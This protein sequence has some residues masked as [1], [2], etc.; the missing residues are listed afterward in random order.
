METIAKIKLFSS[1]KTGLIN[2]SEQLKTALNTQFEIARNVNNEPL[3]VYRDR[4]DA[5]LAEMREMYAVKKRKIDECL[6]EQ[7]GLCQELGEEPRSLPTDP[8]AT[9]EEVSS[10]EL[11]LVDLKAEKLRRTN[12]IEF[13]QRKINELCDS[14][15][16]TT[17]E[18]VYD[19]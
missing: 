11:Y 3:A 7:E 9:D 18:S 14:L 19:R 1:L 4:L 13:L 16:V 6:S 15:E 17:S 5:D 10:F 8:L 12:E 2:E